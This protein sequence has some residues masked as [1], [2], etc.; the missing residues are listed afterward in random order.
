MLFRSIGRVG[1]AARSAGRI[2]RES[3]DVAR[4]DES[5]EVVRQRLA[6][7]QAESEAEIA[8]LAASFEGDA[9]ELRKVSVTPRKSDIAV[10]QVALV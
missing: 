9:V 8:A 1:S 4:A 6:D 3:Q 7:L 5:L 10:G 2:G